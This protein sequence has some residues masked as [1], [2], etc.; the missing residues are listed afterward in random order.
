MRTH[1]QE[2]ASAL[3]GPEARQVVESFLRAVERLDKHGHPARFVAD[4]KSAVW[5]ATKLALVTGVPL[6]EPG[7]PLVNDGQYQDAA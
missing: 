5:E 2:I 3:T 4:M 6:R 7:A 1:A